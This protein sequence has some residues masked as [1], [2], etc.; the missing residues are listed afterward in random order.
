MSIPP[1][2][3]QTLGSRTLAVDEDIN[4]NIINSPQNSDSASAEQSA[5]APDSADDFDAISPFLDKESADSESGNKTQAQLLLEEDPIVS[6][7][8]SSDDSD[9]VFDPDFLNRFEIEE[10]SWWER[11]FIDKPANMILLCLYGGVF[12]FVVGLGLYAFFGHVPTMEEQLANR[13]SVYID[14]ARIEIV[15]ETTP[16]AEETPAAEETSTAEASADAQ[17]NELAQDEALAPAAD[18]QTA[19]PAAEPRQELAQNNNQDGRVS[20]SRQ[21]PIEYG[22]TEEVAL[23]GGDIQDQF[24][25]RLTQAPILDVSESYQNAVLPVKGALGQTPFELYAR[26]ASIPDGFVPI[27][28]VMLNLGMNQMMNELALKLPGD[29]TLG[30]VPY[31]KNVADWAGQARRNGHETALFLPIQPKDYPL[32][33]SGPN[34]LVRGLDATENLERLK[35]VLSRMTG[36]S[37]LIIQDGGVFKDQTAQLATLLSDLAGRGLAVTLMDQAASEFQNSLRAQAVPLASF[38]LMLDQALSRTSF[39]QQ[40]LNAEIE[41]TTKGSYL[42]GVSAYPNNV[43]RLREWYRNLAAQRIA[44]VPL[45][46]LIRY[47]SDNIAPNG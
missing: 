19:S 29:V 11:T 42:I 18:P 5:S 34:S 35:W 38:D 6:M 16:I 47:R 39:M 21:S 9:A 41:A 33:D 37:S 10:R 20:I 22:S 12:V 40:L 1:S 30:F 44:L 15:R 4:G 7:V 24:A 27:A 43:Q 26:P 31:G 2:D 13:P 45:S 36:Y 23:I 25:N 17:A 3:R 32:S 8:A 14:P 46:A 28:V